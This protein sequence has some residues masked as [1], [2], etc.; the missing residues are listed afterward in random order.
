M[1]VGRIEDDTE[2]KKFKRR[3]FSKRIWESSRIVVS[4]HEVTSLLAFLYVTL[5]E[6]STF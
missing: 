4:K 5:G 2:E 3:A 6:S 1:L